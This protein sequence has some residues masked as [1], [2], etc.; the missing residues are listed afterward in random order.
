LCG[1][2]TGG[3]ILRDDRIE[4]TLVIFKI[5]EGIRRELGCIL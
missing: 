5:E 4:S 3:A 1:R 2:V